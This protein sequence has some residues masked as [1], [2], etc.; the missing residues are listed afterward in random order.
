MTR[1]AYCVLRIA[2]CVA[3]S[4][5]LGA[6]FQ[7]DF[8]TNPQTHGWKIFGETNLFYWNATNENLEVTWD[9]SHSNSYFAIAVGTIL[10]RRDDFSF[11][12]DLRRGPG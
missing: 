12:M 2:Y 10:T 8:A 1:I 5:C 3:G 6:T 7:E 4:S 11:A 9:S